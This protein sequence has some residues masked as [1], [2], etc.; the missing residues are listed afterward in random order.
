[1]GSQHLHSPDVDLNLDVRGLPLSATLAIN[2]RS[3][4][5]RRQGKQVFRFGLGQSPFPVPRSV[6]RSLQANAHQKDY[7][8]VRGLP[9]LRRADADYHH[10][11]QGTPCDGADVLIG[12]GSKEWMFLRQLV[13]YGDLVIPTPSWVT[14]VP[15]A[16]IAGR[17]VRWL[18][19]QPQDE[20]RLMPEELERVPAPCREA[21]STAVHGRAANDFEQGHR[22]TYM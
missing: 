22:G 12:P 4:E 21:E 1:M 3:A 11:G 6:V 14:C 19:T 17:H 9:Q 5:L 16:R 8:P 10:R 7:L 13:Y 18:P 15:Q 20:W 2:E